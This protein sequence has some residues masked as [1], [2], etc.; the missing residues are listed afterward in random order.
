MGLD[1]EQYRRWETL[2]KNNLDS[3][4]IGQKH[5]LDVFEKVGF[6]VRA[7]SLDSIRALLD[8]MQEGRFDAY[9]AD[10]GGFSEEERTLFTEACVDLI[11]FQATYFPYQ[12]PVVP[13]DALIAAF[14]IFLKVRQL[15]PDFTTVLEFGPG[16]GYL[17][18]FLRQMDAL[19]NY[20]Q[21]EACESFFLLQN[22]VNQFL[23]AERFRARLPIA[24]LD[25]YRSY[26]PELPEPL[27][28]AAIT[29]PFTLQMDQPHVVNSTR[30][31]TSRN[32][33]KRVVPM[34]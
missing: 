19:E 30:G 18:F 33:G 23:F 26:Y 12:D 24:G 31:G 8:T 20:T 10:L 28:S 7:E 5:N 13:F 34:M 3:F 27:Q 17:A 6:P 4:R 14:S 32:S 29:P 2:A 9:M 16:C 1:I 15:K 21:V 22:K 11:R 25:G